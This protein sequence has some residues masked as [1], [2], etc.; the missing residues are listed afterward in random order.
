[1]SIT[2]TSVGPTLSE[3]A[4][5][6]TSASELATALTTTNNLIVQR[7][8]SGLKSI[9]AGVTKYLSIDSGTSGADVISIQIKGMIGGDWTVDT[10]IPVVDAIG[11]PQA[12]DKRRTID[13]VP[14]DTEAGEMNGFGVPYNCF[15][16]FTNNAIGADAVDEVIILYRSNATM[17][18]TWEA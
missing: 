17:T 18:A 1:M 8:A 4:A 16:S 7:L 9:G 13:W 10:Y 3:I 12:D 2:V 6:S 15:L 11:S 14:A 5:E